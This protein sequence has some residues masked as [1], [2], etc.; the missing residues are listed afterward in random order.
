VK[1]LSV[2]ALEVDVG[3]GTKVGWTT[4]WLRLAPTIL[5]AAVVLRQVLLRGLRCIVDGVHLVVGRHMRLI[6][7][8]QNIFDLVKLGCFAVVPCRVLTMFSR[9]LMEFAQR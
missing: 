9:T 1:T 4:E 2:V 7:R 6:H 8:R 5:L 3:N